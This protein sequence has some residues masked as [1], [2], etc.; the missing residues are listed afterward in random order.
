[1]E[2]RAWSG[3]AVPSRHAL[4]EQLE[5][6]GFDCFVWEDRPTA[7]YAPHAH[8]HD[9]SLWV[10]E[11]TITFGI[12]GTDY[13]LDAGDRLMLPAGTTHSARVGPAGA[14]YLIG[15]KR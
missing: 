2:L 4:R 15:Q 5:T 11:G 13:R 8:D 12:G 7:T 6:D 10:I 14:T 9:E 1:L 3:A